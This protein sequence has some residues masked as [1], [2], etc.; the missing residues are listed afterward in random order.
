MFLRAIRGQAPLRWLS[1]DHDPLYRLHPWQ[2]NLRVLEVAE[3][4]T[5]TGVPCS[6]PFIERW[7][8]SVRR[9][10]LDRILF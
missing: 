1:S 5:V 2:A 9:E 10:Y 6:H 7:I 4:K 8:G 3:I